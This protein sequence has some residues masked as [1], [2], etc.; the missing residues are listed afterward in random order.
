MFFSYGYG[1]DMKAEDKGPKRRSPGE[2][3]GMR[4]NA[5]SRQGSRAR[6]S[7]PAYYYEHTDKS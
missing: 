5:G 3:K 2:G 6:E 1:L 7:C 4:G